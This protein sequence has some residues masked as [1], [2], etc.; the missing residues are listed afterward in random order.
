MNERL[1]MYHSKIESIYFEW[2]KVVNEIES[3]E[4]MSEFL[5]KRK[6]K[7]KKNKSKQTNREDK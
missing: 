4:R 1:Y 7:Q 6:R 2:S 3:F 5:Y